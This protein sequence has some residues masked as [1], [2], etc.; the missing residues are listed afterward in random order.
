MTWS[1]ASVARLTCCV[2]AMLL[3]WVANDAIAFSFG[4]MRDLGLAYGGHDSISILASSVTSKSK[5]VPL[6]WTDVFPCVLNLDETIIP[7]HRNIGQVLTGDMLV[8]SGMKVKVKEGND[9]TVLCSLPMTVGEAA[10]LEKRIRGRYRAQLFLDGLPVMDKSPATHSRLRSRTGLP[11]GNSSTINDKLTTVVYNHFKF[12]IHYYVSGLEADAVHIVQF[13]VEPMSMALPPLPAGAACVPQEKPLLQTTGMAADKSIT[14]SYSVTWVPTDTPFTTRW[15]AYT[16]ENPYESKL[17]WFS[18]INVFFLVVLLSVL[19]WYLFVRAVRHEISTY[20]EEDL[21]GDRED[22]GWK[23]VS[24]DVFRPPRGAVVLS[25]L[26]GNGFQLLSMALASLLLAVI[27]MVSRGSRGMLITLLIGLFVFFAGVNGLVT[28]TLIKFFHR[29]SWQAIMLS[30]VA[31][32]GFFFAVYLGLNFILL[33]NHAASTLPFTSLLYLL[34]LW[35]LISVPL[36]FAGAVVG[37]GTTVSIPVK[38]NTIPRT[39]PP[40]PW[41]MKGTVSYVVFGVVPFVASYVELQSVF[42]SM[43]LGA[44]YHMFGFLTVAFGLTLAIVAQISIL[45]TYYQLQLLN[46]HWAWRSFFVSASYGVWLM[47]YC[48]FYYLFISVVKGFWGMLLYF[49]YMALACVTASLIF[50]AVGFVASLT[51]VRIAYSSIKGD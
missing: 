38:M 43:W 44:G 24:G 39:I 48:T 31:L 37:F 42:S 2:V 18:T 27:G 35:L 7:V 13:D 51:F 49:G 23:L 6:R 21:L 30:A 3:C 34:S 20:N 46:Y 45:S 16:G 41:Y 29:R 11:L 8:D 40:Q 22:S 28:A 15:D 33:G 26:V 4:F 1:S 10:R 5:I 9:C 36:C 32:P 14:F 17:H 50:G 19:M 25:V 12:V 47:A